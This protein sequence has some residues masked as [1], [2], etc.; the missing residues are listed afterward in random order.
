MK[1][2]V[3]GATGYIGSHVTG[4]L[5]EQG[6]DITCFIRDKRKAELRG[7]HGMKHIVGN[8]AEMSDVKA[9]ADETDY[10][11]VIHFAFSLFPLSDPEVNIKGIDNIF[12]AFKGK[13]LKR[14][15][16]ISSGLVYKPTRANEIVDED[17]QREPTMTFA[18]QQVR[19]ENMFFEEYQASGFPIVIIRPSEV[20]GG[21]GGYFAV[22]H[23]E[24]LKRRKVPMIA[25][26][27]GSVCASYVGDIAQAVSRSL[28]IEAAIGQAFN[29]N[30]PDLVTVK[31]LNQFIVKKSGVKE[32]LR[33]PVF[34]AYIVATVAMIIAK[35]T[36]SR[37][38][39]TYDIVRVATMKAGRRNISK[40]K[41][42]LGFKPKYH[43]IF[44]GIEDC[45][46]C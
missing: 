27:S 6:H 42:I 21:N 38:F 32:P 29:I 44:E 15:I 34:M 26:G 10:D 33:V 37:P 5:M 23:L 43:T 17:V 45:Y 2:F 46:Y 14:F 4:A 13:K 25:D 9:A 18:K 19:A 20:F 41:E 8:I 31:E 35:L 22:E 16:Y 1:I 11:A 3:T 30:V 7:D 39:L 24:G 12:H 28:E 36:G 40:A